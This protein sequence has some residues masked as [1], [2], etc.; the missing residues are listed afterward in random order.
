VPESVTTED[1][2][3][4]YFAIGDGEVCVESSS[5]RAEIMLGLKT[6]SDIKNY[7][8]FSITSPANR[9]ISVRV[10]EGVL[11]YTAGAT[12]TRVKKVRC[13]YDCHI[14]RIPAW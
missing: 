7:D 1:V 5:G 14:E 3:M 11:Q 8:I 10:V 12:I 2:R 6:H 13:G 9:P 4:R